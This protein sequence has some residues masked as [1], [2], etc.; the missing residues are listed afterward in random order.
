MMR[1]LIP[2]LLMIGLSTPVLAEGLSCSI[3]PAANTPTIDLPNLAKITQADAQKIALDDVKAKNKKTLDG[4]LEV[5]NGC[6]IYSFD[7]RITKK[8]GLEEIMIDAGT[9]KVL[10]HKHES[11]AQ[12]AVE[13]AQDA[14]SSKMP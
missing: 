5:E 12:E 13:H 4:E 10:S 2:T 9:G 8:S 3:H 11:A 1:I 6:L 7:I 14:K